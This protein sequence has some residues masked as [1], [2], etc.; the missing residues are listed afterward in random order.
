MANLAGRSFD[1]AREPAQGGN[2]CRMNRQDLADLCE[3]S[4][5]KS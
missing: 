1:D 3:A 4:V 5:S 2:P